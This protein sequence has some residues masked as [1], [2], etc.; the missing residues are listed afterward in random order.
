[1]LTGTV[2]VIAS[3]VYKAEKGKGV[4]DSDRLDVK[5]DQWAAFFFSTIHE[6]TKIKEV[7]LRLKDQTQ[8]VTLTPREDPTWP[9]VDRGMIFLE[10]THFQRAESTIDAARLSVD[11]AAFKAGTIFE[12]LRGLS[13]GRVSPRALSGPI[14]IADT[15]FRIAGRD[16][17]EFILFIA[18]F[19]INLAIVN[20]LPIPVLDGGH[21]VFLTYEWLRG[22][23]PSDR[24]RFVLT[25][26]GLI[27][28]L[29]LMS[30][31]LYLDFRRHLFG[32]ILRLLGR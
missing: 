25:I 17:Y 22:K 12:T 8:E 30:F 7:V 31:A 10:E 26:I 9:V 6:N 20:F 14:T 4:V 1:M 2:I 27:L 3:F 13:S 28:V 24:W 15:L 23:P 11:L 29:G 18:F 32:Y 5:E 21:M 16:T 19:N